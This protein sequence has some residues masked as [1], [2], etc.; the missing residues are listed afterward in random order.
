M[1]SFEEHEVGFFTGDGRTG[2]LHYVLINLAIGAGWLICS[3]AT[4]R[5]DPVTGARSINPAMLVLFPVALWL[6]A[7]NMARRLHDRGHS[8]WWWLLSMVPLVG[9][10]LGL[11]LLAA[12]G[13]ELANRYGP[14]P[15]GVDRA[16]LEAK[17][18]A[19]EA[20]QE[21]VDDLKRRSDATY[22]REDGTFDMDWLT[23]S[24]PGLDSDRSSSEPSP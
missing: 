9:F 5:S 7:A 18:E 20:M 19:L 22:Y 2:R 4:L 23:A 11:Y 16:A 6:S 12:P 8:G 3:F 13:D 10:V 24:V 15:G 21:R 1:A 17:R 14:A